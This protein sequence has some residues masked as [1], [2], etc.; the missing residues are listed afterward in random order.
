MKRPLTVYEEIFKKQK[1]PFEKTPDYFSFKSEKPLQSEH[2]SLRGDISSQFITGLLLT[3]PLLEKDSLISFTSP[4]E[5]S[6]WWRNCKCYI[7][8]DN[9]HCGA[10]IKYDYKYSILKKV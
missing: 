9:I 3:L 1:I 10:H 2:Y 8:Y 7:V 6:S 4:L 5:S